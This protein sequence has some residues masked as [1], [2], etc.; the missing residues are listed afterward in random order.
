MM[1]EYICKIATIEE[2]EQNW[3]YL[4]EIHKDNNTW[5]I[6]KEKAIKDMQNRNTIVYYGILNGIVISE[7]TAFITSVNVQNSDGLVNDNTAYLSA[8]RT[9]EEYQGK[10]Y[11]SKLYNFMEKDLKRRGYSKLTLGVEPCETTNIKIYFNYGFTDY[12]KTAY[13][14]YPAKNENE[15]PE[16]ILVNYYSKQL[17]DDEEFFY[18]IVK[19]EEK[20]REKVNAILINEWEATDIIIRGKVIDGTKLDGFIALKN[21]EIIGLITYM[22]E[23]NECEICSLNSFVENKGIG[24]ALI[25]KVK[26]YAEKNSC[27]RIKLITTNDNIRGLEFYQKRGFTFSNLFKNSIEEYSRKLKPQIPLYADNGLPIKDE[28]ELEIAIMQT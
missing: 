8:F 5:K 16:K 22:V 24:T 23:A 14:I 1:G 10:K 13:E 19:L 12:I 28:I 2:M 26:E 18:E 4:V 6:W 7:A 3:N 15:E 25:N 27:S 11:F 17:K 20:D 21:N 9:R